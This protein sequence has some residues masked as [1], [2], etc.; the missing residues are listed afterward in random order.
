MNLPHHSDMQ[1][2]WAAVFL[3]P[4]RRAGRHNPQEQPVLATT[5]YAPRGVRSVVVRVRFDVLYLSP[6]LFAKGKCHREYSFLG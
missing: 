5:T 1:D 6:V 2:P 4:W 3:V